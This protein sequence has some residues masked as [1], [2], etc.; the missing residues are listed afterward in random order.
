M[1]SLSRKQILQIPDLL[2]E[3]SYAQIGDKFGVTAM[4]VYRWV[5]K[6]QQSGKDIT[7]KRGRKPIK[8][9]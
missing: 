6:L 2:A 3:M 8:L 7:I 9:N 4:T 1:S 5:K